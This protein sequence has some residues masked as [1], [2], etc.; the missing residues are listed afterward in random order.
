MYNAHE[1]ILKFDR[2]CLSIGKPSY[3][4]MAFLFI[5]QHHRQHENIDFTLLLKF[6]HVVMMHQW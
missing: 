5:E 2:V 6:G 4:L 3:V 1:I